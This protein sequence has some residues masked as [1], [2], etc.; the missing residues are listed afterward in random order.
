MSSN[1]PIPSKRYA[2]QYRGVKCLNCNHP[3][4]ISDKYCPNCSQINSTKKISFKDVIDEFFSSFISYDSK[5]RKTLAALI[6]KPG[7]ITKEYING[8][9]VAYT[10]PFRFLLSLCIVYFLMLNCTSNLSDIDRFGDNL[11]NQTFT[12]A[13]KSPIKANIKNPKEQAQV[14]GALD[15]LNLDSIQNLKRNQ[16]SINLASPKKFFKQT[17]SLSFVERLSVKIDFFQNA[18]KQ[19]KYYT[20]T[21]AKDS[22]QITNTFENRLSFNMSKSILKSMQQPGSFISSLISKLPFLIFFF[23]PVFAVFIWLIY[24]KRKFNY[25]DH[26]VF[27]FHTQSMLIILLIFSF[28]IDTFLEVDSSGI[29]LILFSLYLLRAMYVFY[30][31]SKIKTFVKF[32]FLNTIFFT[33]ASVSALIFLIGSVFTY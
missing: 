8:K 21:E 6:F 24:S 26:L 9:R 28:I 31:Q 2:K 4:D 22:L 33:L 19:K 25:M 5:I 27:S 1:K 23:L 7:K 11:T 29:F 17:D 18:I 16:D 13:A 14:L 3:L 15:S 30:E 20:F 10:N 12:T 32:M